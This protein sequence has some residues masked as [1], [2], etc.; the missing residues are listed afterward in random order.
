MESTSKF[1]VLVAEDDRVSR[2]VLEKYLQRW[3]YEVVSCDNGNDAWD[4]LQEHSD[5]Y[6]AVLD[7]M[8]PGLS[9]VDLCRKLRA[10]DSFSLLYIV[11]L[12]GKTEK[13]ELV[14]GLEAGANDYVV[15]PFD[16]MD[17]N[18]RLKVG[19]RLVESRLLLAEKNRELR[20]YADEMEK[21]AE[22]RAHMLL[23]ADRLASLGTL[24]AGIAHEIN[25]PTTF[26]SG[27]VQTMQRI[28]PQIE[29]S[30]REV[31]DSRPNESARLG[32]IVDEVPAMMDGIRAGVRRISAIVSGLKS[33]SRVGHNRPEATD[34]HE[35]LEEA[36]MLCANALKYHVKVEK[37]FALDLPKL[38]LDRQQIEQVFVNLLVNAADAVRKQGT[39]TVTI[40]TERVDDK[41][42]ITFHDSGPG[43]PDSLL[44]KVWKPF[45][46]TKPVGEG[47]GLGLSISQ[48]I[49]QDHQ[50]ALEVYNAEEGG[51]VFVITLPLE[52]E[53]R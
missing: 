53:S 3:D 12:T 15:K 34:L 51:A 19:R 52:G 45:F 38:R 32:L 48:G 31:L 27:N 10:E 13:R 35:A 40:T 26:I 8:M 14:H 24:T 21:L 47:T 23:H 49:I 25:N 20:R 6:L 22:E 9:G 41:A 50:G 5:C 29:G 42:R 28:W 1:K 33:F 11:L 36:L 44:E 4:L 37:S 18:S 7:W 30:L 2:K 16:P 46:T 43:I 39:G 17:L